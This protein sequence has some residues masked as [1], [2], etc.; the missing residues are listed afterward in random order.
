[1]CVVVVVVVG[2]EYKKHGKY[3]PWICHITTS[4]LETRRNVLSCIS[5]GR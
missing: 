3:L 5:I 4:F 2:S 1:M